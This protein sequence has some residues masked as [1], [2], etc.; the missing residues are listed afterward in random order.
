MSTISEP[1]VVVILGHCRY[2]VKICALGDICLYGI[3]VV[4][5]SPF[6]TPPQPTLLPNPPNRDLSKFVLGI[7]Y[8]TFLQKMCSGIANSLK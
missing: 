1:R 3:F 6:K 2:F 7:V 5:K 8:N 4:L